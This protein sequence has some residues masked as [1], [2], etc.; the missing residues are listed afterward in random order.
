MGFV[1]QTDAPTSQVDLLDK[2]QDF[3]SGNGWTIDDF[4]TTAASTSNK[5]PRLAL[6][7]GTVYVQFRADEA[8]GG[9]TGAIGVYQSL[10]YTGAQPGG[11]TDDSGNGSTNNNPIA[12]GFRRISGIG[13]GPFI[14][15][16]FFLDDT[17]DCVHVALEYAAGKYRHI[18]FGNLE[19]IGTWTGGEYAVVWN[20][21]PNQSS[22]INASHV[23]GWDL[24]AN[25]LAGE[26][27]TLHI[28]GMPNQVAG[29]KWG[30]VTGVAPA[31]IGNDRQS[32]PKARIPIAGMLRGG[33]LHN[34]YQGMRGN[35]E[36]G[37][38]P[39]FPVWVAYRD[40]SAS[41]EDWYP[42]GKVR[43]LRGINIFYFNPG[44]VLTIGAEEWMTFPWTQ[45]AVLG[46]S[47]E[48]SAYQGIAIRKS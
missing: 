22:L 21:T 13:N 19:K 10:G 48:E 35:P 34:V 29:G 11:N 36:N 20:P 38:V 24:L 31:S 27:G 18:A 42:I 8:V 3:L 16:H 1:Y 47:N 6:H 26:C 46:G 25:N 4:T 43:N 17:N 40:R 39:M 14:A 23:Y 2:L 15:S 28:E 32:S 37:Y 45:K 33:P 41:P 5:T 30:V 7:K 12:S 44:D 9:G